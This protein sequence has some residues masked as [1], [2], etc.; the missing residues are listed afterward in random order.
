[1]LTTL[2][3]SL[4]YHIGPIDLN[5]LWTW[6]RFDE[7]INETINEMANHKGAVNMIKLYTDE[8]CDDCPDFE[9]EVYKDTDCAWHYDGSGPMVATEIYC[10]HRARCA[11]VS[12]HLEQKLRK[13]YCCNHNAK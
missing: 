6:D 7:I 5:T 3:D 10:K 11:C 8:Y 4:E 9:P 12:K 13:K 2:D 1:M